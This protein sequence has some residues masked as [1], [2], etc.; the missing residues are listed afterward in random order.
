MRSTAEIRDQLADILGDVAE[1]PHESVRDTAQLKDL[2]IDSVG[3]V[4]LAEGIGRTFRIPLADETVNEWR[5]VGDLVRTVQRQQ[6]PQPN[7]PTT[8]IPTPMT[9]PERTS[10]FKQLAIFFALVGAGVGVFIGVAAAAL[11]ASAGLDA[12][13]L[14][15]VSTPAVPRPI[16]TSSATPSAEA[17]HRFTPPP[18][19][20]GE[21]PTPSPSPSIVA[22]GPASLTATPDS[23]NSGEEFSLEGR[24]PGTTPGETLVIEISEDGGPWDAFPATATANAD[25]TFS[26]HIYIESPGIQE[27]RVKSESGATTPT[28]LVTIS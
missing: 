19:R 2:G 5:T 6:M 26:T 7:A 13:G 24:L 25:G 12:G 23:V 10:A 11:L 22:R 9:D 4:E 21:T 8:H 27:F 16:A 18:F 28:V 14:P 17:E 20:G 1:V 3:T 15:P